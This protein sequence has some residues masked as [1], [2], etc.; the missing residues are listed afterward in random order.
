MNA[1]SSRVNEI[2]LQCNKAELQI[3]AFEA[4]YSIPNRKLRL[5]STPRLHTLPRF[6]LVPINLVIF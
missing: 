6:H 3:F 5:I 1:A 4:M 2:C